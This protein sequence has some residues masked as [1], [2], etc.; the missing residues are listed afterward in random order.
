MDLL[1]FMELYSHLIADLT[2]IDTNY[3]ENRTHAQLLIIHC[4]E[5]MSAWVEFEF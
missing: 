1:F 5:D 2:D 3:T 4:N